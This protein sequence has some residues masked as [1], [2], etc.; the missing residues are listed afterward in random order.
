MDGVRGAIDAL[1]AQGL[2]DRNRIGLMGWSSRGERV[3]N[4]LTFSGTPIQAASLIDGDANTLFSLVVTYGA[5]DSIWSRKERTNGGLPYGDTLERW[6]RDDPALHTDCV[7]AAVRIETY[8]PTVR[9]TGT[10]TPCCGASTSLRRWSSS[11]VVRTPCRA[12]ASG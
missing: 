9:K 1:V 2:V 5:I 7:T 12:R 11:R 8:G 3:L 4:F 6:I 10:S